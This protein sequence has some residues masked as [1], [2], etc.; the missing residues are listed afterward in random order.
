M[1]KVHSTSST[2]KSWLMSNAN[3]TVGISKNSM[4]NESWLRSYVARNLT[5]IRNTVATDAP[6]NTTFITVLYTLMNVVTKS[7][8]R[9]RYTMANRICDFPEM[10]AHDRVFH[11][12]NNKMIMANK[13]DKSPVNRKIFMFGYKMCS[14]SCINIESIELVFNLMLNC[15]FNFT[16]MHTVNFKLS[17]NEL[18]RNSTGCRDKTSV[19]LI[20]IRI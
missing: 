12:F 10:P 16:L 17:S 13:C 11:I 3:I 4:R 18:P 20:E 6:I 7:K 14:N 2:V 5:N 1:E 15:S 8:Y 9:V 19:K